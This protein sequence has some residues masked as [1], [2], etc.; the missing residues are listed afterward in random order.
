MMKAENFS[1]ALKA[2]TTIAN[3]L[4]Y[5]GKL[6]VKSYNFPNDG[7][8]IILETEDNKELTFTCELKND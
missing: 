8:K 4:G 6:F 5:G 7:L 3:T 1:K 2:T